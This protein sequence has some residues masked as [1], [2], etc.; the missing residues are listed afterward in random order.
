[1]QN[2]APLCKGGSAKAVGDCKNKPI[3]QLNKVF[4]W[5]QSKQNNPSVFAKANPPPFFAIGGDK[6]KC[7]TQI[8]TNKNPSIRRLARV[9]GA[10]K[11][12]KTKR[13]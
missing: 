8:K 13:R 10:K 5:K 12:Q 1:M 7:N 4:K 3:K 11:Q 9:L 6:R 2:K